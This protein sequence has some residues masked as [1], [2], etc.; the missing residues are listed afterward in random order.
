LVLRTLHIDL[1]DYFASPTTLD[2]DSFYISAGEL[3]V[4]YTQDAESEVTP[5]RIEWFGKIRRAT[6]HDVAAYLSPA[7]AQIGP[8]GTNP[9]PNHLD[10]MNTT[11]LALHGTSS[12][13]H[14]IAHVAGFVGRK[15]TELK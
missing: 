6:M 8:V 1:R 12:S 13:P 11:P 14:S 4:E 9:P 10:Y 3:Y 2:R 15:I 5:E 7:H